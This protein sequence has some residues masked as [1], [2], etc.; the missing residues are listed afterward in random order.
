MRWIS[1]LPESLSRAAYWHRGE[2]AWRREEALEVIREITSA[3]FRVIG[4]E[5]WL[6]GGE[7]PLIPA[8]YIYTWDEGSTQSSAG[9]VKTASDYVSSFSW[10]PRDLSVLGEDPYFNLTV[11]D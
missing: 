4:V 6:P 9:R 8:P 10:D 1:H 11:A 2:P 7:G 3:G 5:I